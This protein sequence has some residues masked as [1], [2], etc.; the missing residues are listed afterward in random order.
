MWSGEK[1]EGRKVGGKKPLHV[2]TYLPLKLPNIEIILCFSFA[3]KTSLEKMWR[4]VSF[5]R[6][7][8]NLLTL[9]YFGDKKVYR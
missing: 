2:K 5:S 7:K 3:I 1:S 6:G 9:K 8:K 4:T